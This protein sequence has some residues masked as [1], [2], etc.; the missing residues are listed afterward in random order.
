MNHALEH[1]IAQILDATVYNTSV[2]HGG[3]INDAYLFSTDKGPFFVKTNTASFAADMFAKEAKGLKLLSVRVPELIGLGNSF[4]ILEYI[5]PGVPAPD[6]WEKFG[7]NLAALHRNSSDM[8]GLDH[9]N[10]IGTLKQSNA[11][12][13]QG[14]DFLIME[15]LI[16]QIEL[17]KSSQAIDTFALNAFDNL[18]KKLNDL[19]PDESPALIHGDLWNGNFIVSQEGTAVLIDPSVS[20][21]LRE[22]DLAMSRLFGGFSESFYTA[23]QASYPC[24]PGLQQRIPIYQLYYLMVHVN[25]FGGSYLNSVK[26]ILKQFL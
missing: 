16:P 22:F 25:L 10:Y 5:P 3:D 15:R 24:L 9:D 12:H 18:F 26:A 4:L 17:A 11:K 6:F 21:S 20:Y 13:Q 2:V 19:I 8:F 14:V 7:E 23:Y 1:E